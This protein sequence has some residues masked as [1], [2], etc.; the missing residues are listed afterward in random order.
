MEETGTLETD[1]LRDGSH[2]RCRNPE[3]REVEI[4]IE[5]VNGDHLSQYLWEQE[6]L[7]YVRER[8][9]DHTLT[10]RSRSS[11]SAYARGLIDRIRAMVESEAPQ[12]DLAGRDFGVACVITP[13]IALENDL[14]GSIVLA[15][16][17]NDRDQRFGCGRCLHLQ[18]FLDRRDAIVCACIRV[19]RSDPLELS[20]EFDPAD[21]FESAGRLSLDR[22][23]EV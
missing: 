19:S 11:S 4:G 16:D 21:I 2:R 8:L 17:P 12:R 7:D 22:R 23:C 20:N 13:C 9:L 1:H 5:S 10:E 6:A 18:E 3:H 15:D 14:L